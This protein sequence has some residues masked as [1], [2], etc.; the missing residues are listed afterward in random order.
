M[1]VWK[2]MKKILQG[3]L[4]VLLG[5]GLAVPA[6]YGAVAVPAVATAEA[7]AIDFF[8][9]PGCEECERV[10]AEVIP[11]LEEQYGGF[12]TMVWHDVTKA[13]SVPLLIA[14]QRRCG[15]NDN[16]RVSAVVDHKVFLSGYSE[17]AAKLLECVDD[18][19]VERQ[20]QGWVVPQA[21]D[22]SEEA[23]REEMA[24]Q[25]SALTLLI[26]VVGGITDGFN[27]CAIS[28]LIF[29][30]SLLVAMKVEKRTRLLVGISFIVASFLVYFGLG[31]GFLTFMRRV[32]AFNYIKRYF[33]I[34]IGCALIPLAILSF[35]DAVRFSRSGRPKDVTLQ[36]PNGIKMRMHKVMRSGMGWGG[37]VVSGILIGTAVTVLESVCTGQGYL[38]VLTY[39][40]K[41]G[42]FNMEAWGLLVLYNLLFVMPLTVVFVCFHYGMEISSLLEWSKRN[43]VVVKIALGLFF[44]VV[45]TAL[46]WEF[47][48]DIVSF[49][50][51]RL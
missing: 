40:A 28:S 3:Y 24:E 12:F 16:G 35:R 18:G 26:V 8:H 9:S 15:N 34:L 5:V 30:L 51:A 44:S 25:I 11:D 41:D 14:Y 45:A 17:I 32:P 6:V 38:P 36:V 10:K 20:S 21:P 4:L 22:L 29:F 43:L 46:L 49:I 27:P 39:L 47:A 31:A 13:E 7:V 2:L 50:M 23:V 19:L 37:P 1:V 42:G 33:E 48:S